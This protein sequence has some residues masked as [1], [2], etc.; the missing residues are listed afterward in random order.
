VIDVRMPLDAMAT[1][2]TGKTGRF[3]VVNEG[4]VVGII[5]GADLESVVTQ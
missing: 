3:V 5:E 2:P 4:R 1:R